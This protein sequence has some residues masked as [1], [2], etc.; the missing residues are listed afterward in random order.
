MQSEKERIKKK[1]RRKTMIQQKCSSIQDICKCQH[2]LKLSPLVFTFLAYLLLWEFWEIHLGYW[3]LVLW[4]YDGWQTPELPVTSSGRDLIQPR[5]HIFPIEVFYNIQK[6]KKIIN[7]RMSSMFPL[8]V[9][10]HCSKETE[11]QLQKY[12]VQHKVKA[13]RKKTYNWRKHQIA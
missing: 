3:T 5:K 11:K 4:G 2:I 13:I 8:M 7:T 9:N 10:N 6:K 1:K 12:M